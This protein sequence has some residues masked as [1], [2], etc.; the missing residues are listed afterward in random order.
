MNVAVTVVASATEQKITPPK[1]EEKEEEVIVVEVTKDKTAV[2]KN[3]APDDTG[4]EETVITQVVEKEA[5]TT[6]QKK[7]SENI[8][9]KPEEKNTAGESIVKVKEK[10]AEKAIENVE[11]PEIIN[12]KKDIARYFTINGKN[13]SRET[14]ISNAITLKN[15]IYTVSLQ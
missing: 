11:T 14:D 7:E 6:G 3:T 15:N 5:E 1:T 9:G 8:A 10:T 13:I 4:K 12:L 2:A